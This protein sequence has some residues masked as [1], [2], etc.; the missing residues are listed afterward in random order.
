MIIIVKTLAGLEPVLASELEQMGAAAVRPLKRAVSFEGDERMLYRANYELRTAL[1]VLQHVATFKA[2]DERDLYERVRSINWGQ[3]LTTSETFAIDAVTQGEVFRHSKYASLVV[4]DAIADQFREKHGRRP[5]VNIEAPHVRIHLHAGGSDCEISLDSSGDSLHRRNYRRD[6]VEAPL[7]EV[8]A[9]GMILL[10]GWT[11]D[12]PF[13]DPMCGSG[14]L[15]IEAC[16]MSLRRPPQFLREQFGFFK[17][18]SFNKKLWDDV[19]KTADAGILSAPVAPVFAFDKDI[20]ARNAT[21]INLLA[22]GLENAIHVDK[23]AFEKL[24]APAPGGILM[25]NPPYDERMKVEDAQAFYQG[26][27]DLLKKNWTNWDAW[28]I[29]SNRDALKHLGLR[30]SRRITLFNGALECSF[31]KFELYEGTRFGGAVSAAEE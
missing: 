14:T 30:P 9:A 6:T 22:A 17:W 15:P 11:P 25:A 28:I 21:S 31:Q 20:R 4:K 29:S 8:L 1:R 24:E 26:M 5:S 3:Y 19:K 7:N 16:T 23:T 12:M 27:G 2:R 13:V 18:R 10:S